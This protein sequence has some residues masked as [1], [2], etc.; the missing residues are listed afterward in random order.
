MGFSSVVEDNLKKLEEDQKK[1]DSIVGQI[2]NGYENEIKKISASINA[3]KYEIINKMDKEQN[4]EINNEVSNYFDLLSE[5]EKTEKF[6]KSSEKIKYELEEFSKELRN[7][8]K[9]DQKEV[10]ELKQKFKIISNK[11]ENVENEVNFSYKE[12]ETPKDLKNEN[13]ER[14][15]IIDNYCVLKNDL[16]DQM[17]GNEQRKRDFIIKYN[18][19]KYSSFTYPKFL[20][21][22]LRMNLMYIENSFQEYEKN[23]SSYYGQIKESIKNCLDEKTYLYNANIDYNNLKGNILQI[24]TEQKKKE[25][26]SLSKK[27]REIENAYVNFIKKDIC[28]RMDNL[29]QLFNKILEIKSKN[30][31]DIQELE[32]QF[33]YL[34]QKEKDINNKTYFMPNEIRKKIENLNIIRTNK[35]LLS[36]LIKNLKDENDNLSG[37]I[38]SFETIEKKNSN[39]NYKYENICNEI[40]EKMV[41]LNNQMENAINNKKNK[42]LDNFSISQIISKIK[43]INDAPAFLLKDSFYDNEV[44]DDQTINRLK[45]KEKSIIT[46]IFHEN[47]GKIEDIIL[48]NNKIPNIS[49][50]MVQKISLY[51]D[52]YNYFK[53]KIIREIESIATDNEKYNIDCLNILLVGRKGIGKTTLIKYILDSVEVNNED[54][55]K[56]NDDFTSYTSN[57]IKYLKLIEVKGIGYD[58]DSSPDMIK[59]KIKNYT[60]TI[61]S[62]AQNYNKVI[63]CIWYCISGPRFEEGEESLFN[64]LKEVYKDN[65]MPLILVFT[66]TTDISLAKKMKEKI[67]EKKINNS[68]VNVMAED[69]LLT[70]KKVKKAFGKEELI[71]TTLI[72][73]TEALGSD[74][75]KIMVT[76]ISQN[77]KDNIIEEN[78]N[79]MNEIKSKT[80]NDFFED[81]KNVLEDEE[82]INYVV[83][84]FVKYLD[85]FYKKFK[86]ISNK[87]R[88]LIMRSEFITTIKNNYDSYKIKVKEIIKP[89]VKKKAEE[90]IDLQA[91]MEKNYG[92]IKA[93]NNTRD[94]RQIRKTI[95]IFLKKNYYFMFQNYIINNIVNQSNIYL[96]DFLSMITKE[97]EIIIDSLTN[98]NNQS[99]PDCIL[100]R[101]HLESC[102]KRK[103]NSFSRNN[104]IDIT[105]QEELTDFSPS[106]I[107]FIPDK[108]SS[109]E[110]L[111][112]PFKNSNSFVYNQNEME[113]YQKIKITNL[114]ENWLNFNNF[115]WKITNEELISKIK[116]FLEENKYQETAL[117]S[118]DSDIIFGFLQ[119]EI[120][121]DL[122]NFINENI[123]NYINT[124]LSNYNSQ[125]CNKSFP[126]NEIEDIIKNENIES[127]F[128]KQILNSLIQF[129]KEE[130]LTKIKHISIIITGKSGVGKSTLI[131]CLLKEAVAKEGVGNVITLASCSYQGKTIKFLN[132][133]DTR[134]YEL[135]KKY[136]PLAIKEEVLKKIEEGKGQKDFNNCIQCIWY[137]VNSSKIDDSEIEALKQLK[138]NEY[139]IP[140]IVVFTNAQMANDVESMQKQIKTLIPEIQFI[141]VL[142]RGTNDIKSFGL[143][144]LLKITLNSIKSM[145]QNDIFKEIER[146]YQA[147]E[148]EIIKNNIDKKKVSIINQLVIK[149]IQEYNYVLRES[150]FENH[151]YDLFEK[152]IIAFSGENEITQGTKL[153]IQNSKNEIKNRI[154]SYIKFY[155]KT[156]KNFIDKILEAKSLEY[157]ELQ[158][159]VEKL[160]KEKIMPKVKRNREEFKEIMS[161]FVNDNFYYV[162]QKYLIFRFINDIL[163]TLSE[164]LGNKIISE[165]K[166]FLSSQETL[167]YYKNIYLLIFA[168]FEEEIDKFR[169]KIGNIY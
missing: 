100:I 24:I 70:N 72:K 105:I 41:K 25:K 62:N 128:K 71:K 146:K 63:N 164:Q 58:N 59:K 28:S 39:N 14:K 120:K 137:C 118:D 40:I 26:D 159:K 31:N 27:N 143:D 125:K 13:I 156:S 23:I 106:I 94:L 82:F 85:S 78:E 140:L 36:A 73:C 10:D 144:N 149:F 91:I 61:N 132:L 56:S 101:V 4:Y 43:I 160:N 51:E 151:L 167:G 46:K 16:I 155:S 7:K 81:Y 135:K 30:E 1:N 127:F 150:N 138:D 2:I 77:I 55:N 48:S 57:K 129:T 133:I 67:E 126:N 37:M 136:N 79:I 54:N 165:M 119:N 88:N 12:K 134:G 80:L 108:Y 116:K 95:E 42:P 153:L 68:F 93:I 147:K 123:E 110:K 158:V 76:L 122:I 92:N 47:R 20:Q 111:D 142:G 44:S 35:D 64:S 102:F 11:I 115:D 124:I 107:P 5:K 74:M 117:D 154:Q 75:L 169:D 65:T 96:N 103:V 3:Q 22:N 157:L 130:K 69:M 18:E 145:E 166:Q 139:K 168:E 15:E 6:L 33:N 131:N 60:N 38:D 98:L 21:D 29:K 45:E 161:Q 53:S 112:K 152:L 97:F 49:K 99:D 19:K 163:V 113:D 52:S 9:P 148:E 66:K 83:D 141:S 50:E 104:N 84:I 34:N 90:F 114:K 87:S 121:D 109:D 17:E 162:A 8:K 89:F 32:K 86:K